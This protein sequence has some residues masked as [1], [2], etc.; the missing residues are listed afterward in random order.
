[1]VGT[2]VPNIHIQMCIAMNFMMH[3]MRKS[4]SIRV[5]KALFIPFSGAFPWEMW[6]DCACCSGSSFY[7]SQYYPDVG[8]LFYR[9]EY[10]IVHFTI[11]IGT[12]R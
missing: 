11:V 6:K 9:R 12:A 3:F 5:L 7:Y 4:Y 1:M 10:Y 2:V 8:N